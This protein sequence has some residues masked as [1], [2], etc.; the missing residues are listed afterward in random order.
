MT[1]RGIVRFAVPGGDTRLKVRVKFARNGTIYVDDAAVYGEGQFYGSQKPGQAYRGKIAE[2]LAA[3]VA[4]PKAAAIRYTEL[5]GKCAV[6]ARHLEDET[7]VERGVGP[8]CAAKIG[9]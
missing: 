6:C 8:V 2:A 4:D 9:F 5:T 7:S 3:I 1:S